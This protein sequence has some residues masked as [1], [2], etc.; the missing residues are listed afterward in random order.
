M[1]PRVRYGNVESACR[2]VGALRA[3]TRGE[4][5]TGRRYLNMD[6]YFEWRVDRSGEDSPEEETLLNGEQVPRSATVP[7]QIEDL[8][9]RQLHRI[10][11]VMAISFLVECL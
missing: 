1:R 3:E 2:L 11:P 10:W 6:E 8:A 9:E 4:W 7:A 5:P